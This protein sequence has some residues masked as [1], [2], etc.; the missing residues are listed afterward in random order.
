[1]YI[2]RIKE[3]EAIVKDLS[4]SQQVRYSISVLIKLSMIL[5]CFRI[6]Q[7]EGEAEGEAEAI[8]ARQD[9]DGGRHTMY[10]KHV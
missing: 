4:N 7:Q 1:M 5:Y 9:R 3:L 2:E 10:T 8:R 6:P